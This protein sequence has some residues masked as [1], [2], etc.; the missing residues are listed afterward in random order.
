LN[1]K[2]KAKNRQLLTGRPGNAVTVDELLIQQGI[3]HP[4]KIRTADCR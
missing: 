2:L 1:R 3:S 4:Q